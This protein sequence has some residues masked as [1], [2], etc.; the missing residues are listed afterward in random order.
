M[1]EAATVVALAATT[2]SISISKRNQKIAKKQNRLATEAAQQ[3]YNLDKQQTENALTEQRRKNKNLLAEQISAYRARLGASG[4]S[5]NAG[6]G[7]TYIDTLK[8][9]ADAEDKYLQTQA[10]LSLDALLNGIN[11]TNNRNLLRLN[12][13]KN[14]SSWDNVNTVAALSRSLLK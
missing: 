7:R 4:I 3:K 10:N 13:M 9:E 6:S 8:R 1:V 5:S 14:S 12:S 2:A 11:Q